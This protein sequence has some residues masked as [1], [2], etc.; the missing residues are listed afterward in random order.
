MLHPLVGEI[1]N[2]VLKAVGVGSMQSTAILIP[3]VYLG[4]YYLSLLFPFLQALVVSKLSKN[5]NN[6]KNIEHSIA[7]C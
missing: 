6:N 7:A 1:I 3:P 5:E 2:N 4:T